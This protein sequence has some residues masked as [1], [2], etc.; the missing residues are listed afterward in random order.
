[1]K[2]GT[3]VSWLIEGQTNRGNGKTISDEQDGQV[4]VAV[5]SFAGEPPHGY[6]PVINCTVTWL[7]AAPVAESAPV[8]QGS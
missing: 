2:K 6:H 4:L 7:T 1:M 8:E 5:D 3:R